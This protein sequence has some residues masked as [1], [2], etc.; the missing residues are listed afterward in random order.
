VAPPR[1]G[2]KREV[3]ADGRARAG[4]LMADNTRH[5]GRASPSQSA[6]DS[7]GSGSQHVAHIKNQYF[8]DRRE[9][10]KYDVLE[11]LATDLPELQQLTCLWML[12][13]PDG[14]GQGRVPFVPDPELPELTAFFRARLP[15]A[16]RGQT[17]VGEMSAYFEGGHAGSSPIWTIVMIS[18]PPRGPSTSPPCPTKRF[19]GR[20]CSS[21][22]SAAGSLTGPPRSICGSRSWRAC[23]LVWT[24][25]RWRVVFQYGR[26]VRDF[27][28]VVARQLRDRLNRPLAYIAEPTLAF[29]VLASSEDR[30]D[31]VRDVLERIATRHTPGVANHRLV[32]TAG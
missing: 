25:P 8:G 23:S 20:W 32:A 11:R 17:R 26:R 13:P 18:G 12:T 14:T 21:T 24:R 29:Y 28:T 7:S 4:S 2:P 15:R 22:P 31:E 5:L 27:W 16:I 30:R 19:S 10:F 1:A 3:G 9:Y 6:T